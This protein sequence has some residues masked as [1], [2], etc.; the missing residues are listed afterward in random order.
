MN[1][2]SID[3]KNVE[4]AISVFQENSSEVIFNIESSL[5]SVE[6]TIANAESYVQK[7]KTNGSSILTMVN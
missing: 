1:Q 6:N 5:L 4:S 3:V 7:F 2:L